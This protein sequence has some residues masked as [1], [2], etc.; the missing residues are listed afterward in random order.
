[1]T[2]LLVNPPS[3]AR[4]VVGMESFIAGQKRRLTPEQYYSLPIEHLGIMSIA[5]YARS[6]GIPVSTIN[7]M[8]AGHASVEQTW[9]DIVAASRQGGPPVLIGFT[10]IDTFD[11]VLA[12]VERSRQEWPS[13]RIALGNTF[14]TL[15]Y[16]RILRQHNAID[17]V[18]LGEGEASFTQLAEAVLN[19]RSVDTVPALAWRDV[20]GDIRSTAPKVLDLDDLPWPARDELPTVLG[21]GFA[22][23]VFTTRGCLY[24]CTFCGTGATSDLL[25]RDRYRARSIESVVDEIEFLM[26]DFGV[27]FVSISDD[28]FLAKHPRMQERAATFASEVIR[29]KL[30]LT[31]MFDA[32]VDAIIDLDLLAHLK[33]AGLR[34]V[35]IGLETG[36][37]EQLVSYRK[38]HVAAGED[39]ATRIRALQDL[40]IEVIPGTIMFHPAVRPTELRETVRL[41][42][43]TGYK[44][45][46]K[47]FDRITAYAGTPLY[48][49]YAAKGYLSNDWPVGE[50]DFVDPH[51]RRLYEAVAAH[52]ARDEH[53]SFEDAEEYFLEQV[54]EW[55]ASMQADGLGAEPASPHT[56]LE[57][58]T[59]R[60]EAA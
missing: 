29:R 44:T 23:A 10:N 12:L 18:V 27:D 50:W 36:S 59:V 41:L 58:L 19:D 32:R 57:I 31:F 38:R 11:E 40:G 1:V 5:A 8:V 39:P 54:G 20:E 34:R 4:S 16:D 7:G 43:A 17:Y 33:Q 53:I 22:G 60:S 45:P 37:Y 28:L 15:N 47:L 6:K 55:E 51:A 3:A 25:G 24:R 42:K 26:T 35:F 52:I 56:P 9:A 48:H 46:R 2:V 30:R 49:E 21:E 14:A 13:V